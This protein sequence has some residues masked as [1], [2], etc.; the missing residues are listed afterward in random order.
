MSKQS[1]RRRKAKIRAAAE[2]GKMIRFDAGSVDWIK[3]AEGDGETS[4]KKFTMTAYTG[5]AMRVNYYYDPVVIEL[6]GLTAKA[7]L[8][9]LLDHD[10]EKIVGHADTVDVGASTLKLAGIVSGANEPARQ[11]TESAALGFPW[12]ASVGA[13][14]DKMEFIGEGVET[15][16][17][18]KTFKG[19]LY[20]ARKS[21][22]GEV[23]FVPIAADNKTS[24]KV[25]ARAAQRKEDNMDFHEWIKALGFDPE[26]VTDAQTAKLEAKFE[27]EIKA[28]IKAKAKD[29]SGDGKVEDKVL[30][31]SAPTFDPT[32]VCLTYEKHIATVQAKAATYTGKIDADKLVKIQATAGTKAVELKAQALNEEKP[33]TWLE[34]ELIKAQSAA[35]VELIRA[36]RPKGPAI[37]GSTRDQT[38]EVLEAAFCRTLGL[39]DIEKQFKPEV[40]EASDKIRGFGIQEL[41]LRGAAEGGYRGRQHV[42]QNN[43]REILQAAFS[44][45]SV[46]TMLTQLGHKV[47]LSG[48]YAM[49]QTWREVAVPSTV[50]DFKQVTAFRLTT[51]L[52]YEELSPA[53][54]IAHGTLGQESYTRQAKTYAKMLTL[55]RPDIIN[56]D[57]GAFNDVRRRLGIGCALKVLKEFWTVWLAAANAGTFWTGARANLITSSAFADAGIATGVKAFRTLRGP[58]GNMMNLNPTKVLVPPELEPTA[59]KYHK[60][61]ELRDTTASTK[62]AVA[63]IYQNRFKPVVVPELSTAAYTGYSATNWWML[64]D[65]AILASASVCFLDGVET[66]VIESAAADFDTLGIQLRGYHDFGV[67]MT[68]YLA[69]VEAQA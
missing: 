43:V 28:N 35:E 57:L 20:V 6:T 51:S 64:C 21:T 30:T 40:L 45:H 16:V 50:S 49:P 66:P 34:V 65:P 33:A 41:L 14:P 42:K 12:K 62:L 67:Q 32:A 29:A 39:P 36:E 2:S 11:V 59:L 54:E 25:A 46:T 44:V 17:N 9:I 23:S 7:P 63:N 15:T 52:E 4:S 27:A 3:A 22:L 56:D 69:S 10:E 8:P 61:A 5:G 1:D 58:D 26:T 47:L 68:E 19:P 13:R 55:T 53:G 60:S 38:P 37:H 48:F 31:A 18:G 24:V